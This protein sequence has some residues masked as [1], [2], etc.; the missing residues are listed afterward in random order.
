MQRTCHSELAYL[1]LI[2]FDPL[3]L[4]PSRIVVRVVLC[5]DEANMPLGCI[6]VLKT[7]QCLNR[8]ACLQNQAFKTEE[9]HTVH[10]HLSNDGCSKRRMLQST[11][12]VTAC[13]GYVS[14]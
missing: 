1:L 11:G 12:V 7:Q 13:A 4:N 10:M 5:Q 3:E 8:T 14:G 2:L 9:R 6:E